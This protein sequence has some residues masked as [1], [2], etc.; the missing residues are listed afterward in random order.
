MKRSESCL[1]DCQRA[2]CQG[3][4][5]GSSAHLHQA[6]LIDEDGH[7]LNIIVAKCRRVDLHRF[8]E[9]CSL[10]GSVL[11]A[12]DFA[13]PDKIRAALRSFGFFTFVSQSISA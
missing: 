5:S 4:A 13:S 9:T 12:I 3:S 8:G 11:L 6:R 1:I 10:A 7:E 2:F